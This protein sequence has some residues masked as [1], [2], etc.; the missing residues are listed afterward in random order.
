MFLRADGTFAAPSAGTVTTVSVATAN[1]ISGSVANAST[2]P[3]LTL[4][5][6]AITP[7]SVT[8]QTFNHS[9][10][11][12][13]QF[14]GSTKLTTTTSGVTIAGTL[15]VNTLNASSGV[16]LQFNGS[17]KLVTVTGGVNVNGTMTSTGNVVAPNHLTT[18]SGFC[19]G[20]P[21]ASEVV[22]GA[23]FPV[24][25]TI[26][27]ANCRAVATVAATASTVFTIAKDGTSVGTITFAAGATLGT[28]SVTSGAI[29]ALQNVTITAP[30]TADATLA[31]ISFLVRA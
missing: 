26:T 27:Q 11:L 21:A 3:T 29:T 17:T 22:G 24:A 23:I 8:S 30:A 31:N 12:N 14:N 1:G 19:S 16:N 7:T 6:G 15:A 28:I 5:L 18:M 2:T 20:K 10:G 4:T 13:L 25:T 9:S